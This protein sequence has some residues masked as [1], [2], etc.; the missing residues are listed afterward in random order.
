[1]KVKYLV[2][3][4]LFFGVSASY[5]TEKKQI[6]LTKTQGE[7]TF[8]DS[9]SVYLSCKLT[10]PQLKSVKNLDKLVSE[11]FSEKEV[12]GMHIMA[13]SPSIEYKLYSSDKE[14]ILKKDHESLVYRDGKASKKIISILDKM[15]RWK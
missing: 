1:M 4:S 11:A 14:L 3:V 8:A 6:Y 12:V 5:K 10:A 7:Y 9:K 13:Q 15:C 2:L